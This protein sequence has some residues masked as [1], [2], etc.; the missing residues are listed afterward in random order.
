MRTLKRLIARTGNFATMRSGD[1]RLREEVEEHLALQ[2]GAN[3]REGMTPKEARRQAV[4]KFGP[5][6]AVREGFHAEEGLPLIEGLLQDVRFALRMLGKAPAFTLAAVLTL[7]LGIGANAAIFALVNALMLKS[8]PVANPG[9]LL[10]L[11]NQN[12]CCV[13]MGFHDNGDYSMFTTDSYEFLRKNVPEFEDLTAI[14]AGFGYRPVVV[15]R[16]GSQDSSRSVMGEFVSGN[17]FRTFGLKAAAGRLLAD[18]DDV[19]GAPM[20]ALMS[21]RTWKSAFNG[22]PTVVGSTFRV[23]TKPVTIVGVAPDGFYGDRL[24]STPPEFY[25]PIESMPAIANV[26]YVHGSDMQWLYLIG[27]VRPGVVQAQLQQKVSALLRQQLATTPPYMSQ[28][29]KDKLAKM[30]VVLTAGGGGIQ[31]MQEEYHRHLLL[32]MWVSGLV[33]LI[34]CA[35]IA[36]LL[37]VRGMARKTEMSVRTALGAGRGRIARQLLT[38]SVLLALLGGV[39]GLVVAYAGTRML[40]ALA[41]PGAHDVPIQASPSLEVL[42]FAFGLSLVTGA[43][44]GVAPAWIASRTEPADALRNGMRST[45]GGATLL[46]RGLVV[47]Q[48]A[49]SLVLLVGAGMFSE[50]L[51]KLEHIDLKLDARNRY[52]VHMNPQTAG[53]GQR[54]VGDLYRTIEERFHALPGVDKV[55]ISSYTP[56][57]DNNNSWNVHVQGKPDPRLSASFIKANPEYF[58]S[59]GTK[60]VRGRGIGVQDTATSTAVAV[61]NESFVK[62]LFQ[63]GENPIGQHF[64]GGEKSAGDYEIVGVVEDTAYQSARWKDHM[65]YF[66]PLLQR[67]ASWK[68]PI[69]KDEDM[70]VGAIV[71]KTGRPIPDMEELARKTLAGINPNL[72]VVKF[73]SFDAQIGDQFSEERMLARLTMLFGVLAL[74][75]AT[76]GMYGVTAYAVARRTPEIGI[77]MALGA[78]RAGVTAM[79]MRGAMA[80][81]VLG[82][83]IGVPTALLCVR[84]V[85]AQL[86]EVKG[87]DAGVLTGSVLMLTL[88]AS[89][90]A[91]IPAVRAASIDPARALRAE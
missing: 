41:F 12:D 78:E 28:E 63:P 46:Q 4:L 24:L 43:L 59:V 55:G 33:L 31:A 89:V 29:R 90:A 9:T 18:S 57:E 1:A 54:Q 73:Q 39:A 8:L 85:V 15:R 25:L 81:T 35:N 38:E 75:L 58:D 50:S 82:L 86:Y 66:T 62:K 6:E 48:A 49:L 56:M 16:D 68:D 32:L 77:R 88:A 23:N 52:I 14:Q 91:L 84:F 71:L 19:A 37:L 83:G 36:N 27:R 51:S 13:G 22:D 69:E 17:Y 40:L 11:G 2:T 80:E 7:A 42:A 72:S 67:P 30:H 44:F 5:V 76:L 74:L 20:T 64:G 3:M 10:R 47:F 53:Y 79:V 21:Y 26:T 60:V 34:A 87:I 61:V 70:Y 45:A 65:M